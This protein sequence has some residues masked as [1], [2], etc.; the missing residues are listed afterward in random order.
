MSM[1]IFTNALSLTG[2]I[3]TSTEL[4]ADLLTFH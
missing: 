4:M 1:C 2:D 3:N